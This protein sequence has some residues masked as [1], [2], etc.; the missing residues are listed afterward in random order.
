MTSLRERLDYLKWFL[1]HN[2]PK[3]KV[4]A[5]RLL[6]FPF[7]ESIRSLSPRYFWRS[8][9]YLAQKS[10]VSVERKLK[11]LDAFLNYLDWSLGLQ[12]S[13]K[14]TAILPRKPAEL[15]PRQQIQ[16]FQRQRRIV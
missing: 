5:D 2:G 12:S 4:S 10:R 7:S 16:E 8:N 15:S 14:D 6:S 11:Y 1:A 3:Q 9:I 13:D